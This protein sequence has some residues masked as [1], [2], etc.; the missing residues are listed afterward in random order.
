MHRINNFL[1]PAAIFLS[2]FALYGAFPSNQYTA[3][4]GSL[5]CLTYMDSGNL[6]LHGNN[7]ALYPVNVVLWSRVMAVLFKLRPQDPFSFIRMIELMN[8][9][10]GAIAIAV[11][12][13][14]LRKITSNLS[15]SI[16]G[17]LTLAF[18][19][20]FVVNAISSNEP[21]VGFTISLISI[22]FTYKWFKMANI[23]FGFAGAFLLSFSMAIYQS[24]FLIAPA[25]IL[26][27]GIFTNNCFKS[28]SIKKMMI[29]AIFLAINYFI[30]YLLSHWIVNDE[31]SF[32]EIFNPPFSLGAFEIYGKLSLMKFLG[33]P[34]AIL[35][36]FLHIDSMDHGVRAFFSEQ[37]FNSTI[38][39]VIILSVGIVIF[40]ILLACISFAIFKK[41]EIEKRIYLILSLIALICVLFA[42]L[43]WSMVYTKL[44]MQP[45]AI[46]I[47]I[48][49][50]VSSE[51]DRMTHR[52]VKNILKLS[53]LSLL[54]LL[55]CWNFNKVLLDMHL[56]PSNLGEGKELAELLGED[57]LMINDWDNAVSNIY[58]GFY[59]KKKQDNFCISAEM[60]TLN[61]E[62]NK[63]IQKLKDKIALFKKAGKKV[64]FLGILEKSRT[65]WSY[66]LGER[67]NI[68]YNL[69]DEYR[70]TAK[71]VRK[72]EDANLYEY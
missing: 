54:I 55:I 39:T 72:F 36:G 33:Y 17:A 69:F 42:P 5:R 70:K 9:F 22:V 63:F 21:M 2:L 16:L 7:H 29:Y 14:I 25:M 11:F 52:Y 58:V 60:F 19:N 31:R 65:K 18:S 13:T 45:I 28:Q 32:E 35:C 23:L 24:M 6:R 61:R 20:A 34:F 38:L 4:D 57:S 62:R 66:F 59:K 26:L 41:M 71:L 67:L 49:Y 44:L 10:F 27:V 56:H 50:L 64:F 43:Y 46:F 40:S 8:S 51:L 37:P 1:I 15:I 30:I 53:L 12:F 48:I 47:I 68:D 3:V